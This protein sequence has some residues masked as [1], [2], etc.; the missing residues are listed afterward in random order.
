M[1]K[2]GSEILEL[3]RCPVTGSRLSYAKNEIV[4]QLNLQS[5]SG[6]LSDRSGQPI[7]FTI[8]AALINA[9]DSLLMPIRAG[10][11][12]MAAARAIAVGA[13]DKNQGVE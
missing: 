5:Q 4:E 6:Q 9:D 10:V 2:I 8:D 13:I 12:S 7:N 11:V 3:L 1:K